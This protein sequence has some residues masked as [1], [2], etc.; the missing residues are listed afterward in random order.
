MAP[1]HHARA[2]ERPVRIAHLI[3]ASLGGTEQQ[4]LGL[5]EADR[6]D[7]FEHV[8][9][10]VRDGALADSFRRVAATEDL[11]KHGKVDPGFVLRLVA[12]LR[13]HR[14]DVL[15]AWTTTPALWGPPAARLARVP[16]VLIADVAL[17]EWK[18]RV[19]RA[20]DRANYRLADRVV[21]CAEAVT[22]AA[23][24]RG[25]PADRTGTVPLGVSLPADPPPL[26]RRPEVLL[27]GRF[28]PRK[29]HLA[30]IAALP[31]VL[32]A[33]PDSRFRLCGPSASPVEQRTRAA[34]T[35]AVA[36]AGVGSAVEIGDATPVAETM[37]PAAVVVVPS[38]S[39]GLPNVVM[40]AFAYGRP[41]V[42]TSVGGIPE[43]VIDGVTGW[44]V[45]PGDPGALA[46]ALI[47]ALTDPA[48]ARR[49]GVAGRRLAET[50][51]FPAV[52][53]MWHEQY[54]SLVSGSARADRAARTA[55]PSA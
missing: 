17:E 25:A 3:G 26:P 54:D 40:E 9:L 41:V 18:G 39:E 51:S 38:T 29:G 15:H 12:A 46:A 42:A 37:G 13:R 6:D 48:E 10:M 2:A 19:L 24:H 31:T 53:T 22:A 44:L 7:R 36:A 27:L 8:V 49:R 16:F 55:P 20:A 45:P 21:G 32:A 28:D 30:L 35:R 52:V 1:A 34:V 14:P 43:V 11:G 50:R 33:V 4:L 5:L 47:E 23:V